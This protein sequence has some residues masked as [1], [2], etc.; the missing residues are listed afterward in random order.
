MEAKSLKF[1]Q[2]TFSQILSNRETFLPLSFFVYG[3]CC[4]YVAVVLE[5]LLVIV[6]LFRGE[7]FA[8]NIAKN[9]FTY[10]A[11]HFTSIN[12]TISN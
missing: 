4:L 10:N 6:V 3:I 1:T 5:A 8:L 7:C 11:L 12:M 2:L 9:I